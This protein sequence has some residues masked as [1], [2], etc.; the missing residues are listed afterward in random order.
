MNLSKWRSAACAGA[1]EVVVIAQGA[2]SREMRPWIWHLYDRLD[3]RLFCNGED[4]CARVELKQ[5]V[6]HSQLLSLP[7]SDVAGLEVKRDSVPVG[8]AEFG[9]PM[10]VD[11]GAHLVRAELPV[12]S[13]RVAVQTDLRGRIED[14]CHRQEVVLAGDAH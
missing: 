11:P 6:A 14:E 4:L 3:S 12:G 10:P 5:Y 9:T 1:A 8:R 13:C 2:Q 7:E